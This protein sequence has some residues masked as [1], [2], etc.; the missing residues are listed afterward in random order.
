MADAKTDSN[1]LEVENY[2]DGFLSALEVSALPLN[3]TRLV[4]L[5]ACESGLGTNESGEGVQ[6]IRRAFMTAGVSE[7]V[8][9][10]WRIPDKETSTLMRSFYANFHNAAPQALRAAQLEILRSLRALGKPD[11]PY[12]WGAFVAYGR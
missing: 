8:T 10:L 6:G 7:T 4:V 1:S 12:S 3:S 9:S 11:H 2:E 5:S